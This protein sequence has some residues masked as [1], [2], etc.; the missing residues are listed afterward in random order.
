MHV[1]S[2]RDLEFF[3][4]VFWWPE[5]DPN[6][7][8]EATQDEQPSQDGSDH[9]DTL[10]DGYHPFDGKKGGRRLPVRAAGVPLGRFVP[11]SVTLNAIRPPFL[12]GEFACRVDGPDT[13][14]TDEHEP[15]E[16]GK[17]PSCTSL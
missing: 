13:T 3:H 7:V 4:V 16:D 14:A 10:N 5:G 17:G 15:N 2:V 6:E 11:S 9:E 12:V 1:I 8:G